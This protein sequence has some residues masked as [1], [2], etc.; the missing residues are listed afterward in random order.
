MIQHEIDHLDGVLIIDRTAARAAAGGAREA[1][2]RS[3]FSAASSV[4][5]AAAGVKLLV[6]ATAPF[7]AAVLEGLAER[8]EIELLVTRPDR[9]RGR[10]RKLGPP[11]AKQAAERLGIRV[12]Q[13]ERLE[14]APGTA[15][16]GRR[17]CLRRL[18]PGGPAR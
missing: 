12:E 9:P 2:A 11:P 1:P 5:R 14:A 8:H 15:R 16:R 10:G 17:V 6:A 18:H 3:P 7:G 4:D 13:P